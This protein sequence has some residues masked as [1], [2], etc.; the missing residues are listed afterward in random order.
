MI[1][2][3]TVVSYKINGSILELIV[4]GEID[5]H[6]AVGLRERADELIKKHKP[7]EVALNLE[8]IGFMDSSGLG[9]IMGRY[10]LVKKLGGEL[11]LKN[12]NENV[13][14]I[15]RLAGLERMIKTKNGGEK[16]E[17]R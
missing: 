10:A 11:V 13:K 8:E 6:S 17:N 5:H 3:Q 1:K 12:P 4:M 14:R 15:C 2:K 9:F 16:N 7:S